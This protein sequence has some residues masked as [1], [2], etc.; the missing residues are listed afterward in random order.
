MKL[1]SEDAEETSGWG[2]ESA[3]GSFL[4]QYL[5]RE[6]AI[7]L[8]VALVPRLLFMLLVPAYIRSVDATNWE[9]VGGL[10]DQGQNPYQTT[11]LLN[12]PPFWMQ[13][14]FVLSKMAHAYGIQFFHLLQIFLMTVEAG[15]IILLI[16]LIREVAPT[17]RVRAIAL[18]G[19]ALN[20][21][22][23]FLTCQH[24][25]FDVMVGFWVLLFILGFTR[26]NR[27][28]EAS[29]WLCACLFLGLGILTKTVPLILVPMLAGG[30]RRV[31]FP[32]R[33]VGTALVFGPVTLAMSVIYVLSPADVAEKVIGY[34]SIPGFFGIP[35]LFQQLGA[36]N[37]IWLYNGI[38]YLALLVTLAGTAAFFWRRGTIGGR[39]GVLY[40][41]MLLAAV[42]VF[43]PGYATQYLYWCLPLLVATYAFFEGRWRIFLTAFGFVAALTYL[44]LCCLTEPEG[45]LL[46]N[47]WLTRGI[48]VPTFQFL[49]QLN[50]PTSRFLFTLP[51]FFCY[52]ALIGLGIS[53]LSKY[54]KASNA[55]ISPPAQGT[56][57]I[58]SS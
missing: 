37:L 52:L 25:N 13:I 54:V 58:S 40:T 4:R 41:A 39:E 26:Y 8:A 42:P 44:Y 3:F 20:P 21:A 7:V 5:D 24:G 34:R 55:R 46:V 56:G 30:F 17:A 22:A 35:G 23:I 16:K 14:I 18:A 43:G 45:C 33:L 27:S 6:V 28:G 38:F 12:W 49:S 9:T 1:T 32:F 53:M 47:L 50:S 10:M 36:G 51:L 57:S 2:G 48:E 11:T 29:D 15:V 19:I 31:T